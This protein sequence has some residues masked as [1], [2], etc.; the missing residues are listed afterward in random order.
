[1]LLC[2]ISPARL[3][4]YPAGISLRAL[5]SVLTTLHFAH[6]CILTGTPC[7]SFISCLIRV[8][9]PTLLWKFKGSPPWTAFGRRRYLNTHLLKAMADGTFSQALGDTG[10]HL[11]SHT[12]PHHFFSSTKASCI[13]IFKLFLLLMKVS[14]AHSLVSSWGH[15]FIHLSRFSIS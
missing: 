14:R 8:I 13:Y 11:E 15:Y 3:Y 9:V 10:W 7:E 5:Y 6:G 4:V 2:V 1:M 12:F